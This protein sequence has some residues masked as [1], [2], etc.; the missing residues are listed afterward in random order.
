MPVY[1]LKINL[2]QT[3]GI[4]DAILPS[5]A[6][7]PTSTAERVFPTPPFAVWTSPPTMAGNPVIQK[8]PQLPVLTI[9]RTLA[10]FTAPRR[11]SS[12]ARTLRCGGGSFD[13]P[14]RRANSLGRELDLTTFE[15]L[16]NLWLLS[17]KKITGGHTR[18]SP[19]VRK[20]GLIIL[21][22]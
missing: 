7:S 10:S 15:K 2:L 17:G 3:L 21:I 12:L 14:D 4:S 1:I 13:S 6:S 16:S 22:D 11:C 19:P 5:L 8:S 9:W 18:V 20:F